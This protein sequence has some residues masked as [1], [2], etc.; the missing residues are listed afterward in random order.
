MGVAEPLHE[1]HVVGIAPLERHSHM[2]M[3]VDQPGHQYAAPT[4]DLARIGVRR[5]PRIGRSCIGRHQR[6]AAPLDADISLEPVRL[7]GGRRHR[8][9]LAIPEKECHNFFASIEF[10]RT[11]RMLRPSTEVEKI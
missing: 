6:D 5:T 2:A 11:V 10:P 8:Q 7:A 4:V 3:G 9:H 1:R